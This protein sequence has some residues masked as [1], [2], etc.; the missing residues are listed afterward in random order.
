MSDIGE[1]SLCCGYVAQGEKLK[2]LLDSI[3]QIRWS[4][5]DPKWVRR[6]QET[7]HR[8]PV[9]LSEDFSPGTQ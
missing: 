8:K 3:V 7:W 4:I 1:A 6:P 9:F 5:V 2:E